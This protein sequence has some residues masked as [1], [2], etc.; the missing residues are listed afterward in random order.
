MGA[1]PNFNAKRP[2]RNS[3]HKKA[4]NSMASVSRSSGSFVS[5]AD[6][7]NDDKFNRLEWELRMKADRKNKK[8]FNDLKK[9]KNT[10]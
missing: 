6:S 7:M 9:I 10:E 2:K 4:R 1:G 3:D 5:A 8:R